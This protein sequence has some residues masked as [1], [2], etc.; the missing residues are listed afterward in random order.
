MLQNDIYKYM[1]NIVICTGRLN[2]EVT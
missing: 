1:V 2:D